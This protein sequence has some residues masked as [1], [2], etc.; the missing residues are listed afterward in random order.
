[1]VGTETSCLEADMIVVFEAF[2]WVWRD[3]DHVQTEDLFLTRHM[4][5][6]DIVGRR[7][8]SCATLFYGALILTIFTVHSKLGL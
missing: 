3:V 5:N 7:F 2:R 4:F 6:T 1:M 8:C